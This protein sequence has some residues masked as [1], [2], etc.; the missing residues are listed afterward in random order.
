M[1]ACCLPACTAIEE[2]ADIYACSRTDRRTD[3]RDRRCT[4]PSRSDEVK[5][6]RPFQQKKFTDFPVSRSVRPSVCLSVSRGSKSG[7]AWDC[8]STAEPEFCSDGF[9]HTVGKRPSTAK[10]PRTPVQLTDTQN[11]PPFPT[12]P[13]GPLT[14]RHN[15]ENKQCAK[16]V[17]T[18]FK[19]HRES[20]KDG[21]VFGKTYLVLATA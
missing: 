6:T 12:P 8:F 16:Y 19:F 2:K 14:F 1:S 13:C 3:D 9:R 20:Y 10:T 15:S 7:A 21:K 17:F 11:A 18:C 4:Y 5:Q